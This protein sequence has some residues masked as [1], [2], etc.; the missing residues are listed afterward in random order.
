MHAYETIRMFRMAVEVPVPL[1]WSVLTDKDRRLHVGKACLA[2]QEEPSV[3]HHMDTRRETEERLYT[4]TCHAMAD[5]L[6]IE[7]ENGVVTAY[8]VGHA[9]D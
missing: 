2:L 1:P 6:G 8:S 7:R 4:Q 5:A 3:P 9:P